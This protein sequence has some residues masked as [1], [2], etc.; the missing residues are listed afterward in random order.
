[1]LPNLA[2]QMRTAF[3]SMVAKHRLQITGRAGNDAQDFG[4]R[5]LLLQRFG[6][7]LRARLDFLLEVGV[8]LLQP[9][10]HVV[11]LIGQRLDFVAGLDGDALAEVAGAEAGGAGPQRLDRH[12]HAPRQEQAGGEG[13]R[14][15][16]EE[17]QRGALERGIERRV[18]FLDRRLNED[19]PAERR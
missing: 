6:Q 2:S 10:G 15:R 18:G 16:A 4:C 12:H 17:H 14:Q 1:M 19:V 13:E 8:G 9:S 5:R 11:E 3:S 7:L